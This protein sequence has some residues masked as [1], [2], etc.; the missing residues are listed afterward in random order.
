MSFNRFFAIA[1]LGFALVVSIAHAKA[2]IT[3]EADPIAIDPPNG[4]VPENLVLWPTGPSQSKYALIADKS[5]RT[6]TVWENQDGVPKFVEAHPMDI[7]KLGGIKEK[8]GDHKTPEGIYFPQQTFEGANLDHDQ[9]GVKAFTLDYPNYFDKRKNK[10]GSGIWL[11]A[12]PETKSLLRG[13]RGCVVVRNDIIKKLSPLISLK[14]TPVII[15][16][17]V[18]YIQVEDLKTRSGSLTTW[19]DTW[20]QDWAKKQIDAYMSHYADDFFSLSMNKTAWKTYKENLNQKYQSID[21][22]AITPLAFVHGEDGIL[23]F[24][25]DYKS[26]VMN[27][28]GVK[29][30]YLKVENNKYL[31]RGEEWQAASSDTIASHQ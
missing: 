22:K 28:F 30:L 29:T 15:L 27:D 18:N 4:K 11:H 10:T 9:Y 20:K 23:K 13:S 5:Q 21:V 25:Q 3:K 19:L 24:F 17:Q 1:L 8:V 14:R 6:L 16:N 26:D 7:G 2:D 31:I 12:I